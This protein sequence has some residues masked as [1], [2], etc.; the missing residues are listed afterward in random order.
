MEFQH[1]FVKYKGGEAN[2]LAR[3]QLISKELEFSEAQL[4]MALSKFKDIERQIFLDRRDPEGVMIKSL[5]DSAIV[6]YIKC[7]NQTKGRKVKLEVRDFFPLPKCKKLHDHHVKVRELRDSYIAHAGISKNE[8]SKMVACY[9]RAVPLG[10]SEKV[11]IAHSYFSVPSLEFIEDTLCLVQFVKD[12]HVKNQQEKL[13]DFCERVLSDPVKYGVEGI[14]N[15][16]I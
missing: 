3:W 15:L 10:K 7:F 11:V 16:S 5:I 4:E 8:G 9:D 2:Q 13:N 6:G 14:F 12:R 1:G